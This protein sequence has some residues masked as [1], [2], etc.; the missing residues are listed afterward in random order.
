MA[1]VSWEA[2]DVMTELRTGGWIHSSSGVDPEPTSPKPLSAAEA[3]MI[4]SSVL[5]YAASSNGNSK[6]AATAYSRAKE[7]YTPPARDPNEQLPHVDDNWY[8]MD[9][10]ARTSRKRDGCRRHWPWLA[11]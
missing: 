9:L 7:V 1:G 2:I 11:S 4:G 10:L 3:G 8:Y 6:T 5:V